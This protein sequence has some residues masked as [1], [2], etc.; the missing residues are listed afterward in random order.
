M[1]TKRIYLHALQNM[2]HFQFASHVII[3]CEEANIAKIKPLLTALKAAV[4][5]EDLALNRPRKEDGT[6]D[7]EMLDK[8]RDQAYRSLQLLVKMHACSEDVTL[9]KAALQVSN[10]M[11]C[12][13]KLTAANYDKETGMVKNLVTDLR[14]TAMTAA[15]AKLAAADY[16]NRLAT[17]NDLFDARYQSRLKVAMPSGTFDVKALRAATDK[18]LGA[19]LRRIEALDELEPSVPVSEFITHYNNLVHNR[20]MLLARRAGMAK[21]ARKKRTAEY[22]ELLKSGLPAIEQQLGLTAGTLAVSGKAVGR[23]LKRH[24]QLCVNGQPAPDGNLATIW[25]GIN[26]DGSLY[27]YEPKPKTVGP[28]PKKPALTPET[29]AQTKS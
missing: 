7:L 26:K 21:L 17:A 10:V 14:A 20:R 13:P 27:R 28:K 19:V 16:I 29:P 3:M 25:V 8:A 22:A 6:R 5:E 24:Y 11:R 12:Y 15:V 2:E 1:K 18:A 9:R 23:G 4:A